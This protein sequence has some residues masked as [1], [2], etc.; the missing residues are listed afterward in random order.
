MEVSP[1]GPGMLAEAGRFSYV[2]EA[3]R[4]AG[5]VAWTI[6][7]GECFRMIDS[8]LSRQSDRT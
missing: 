6:S 1:I 7:R 5:P 2:D 8:A 3:V 4:V